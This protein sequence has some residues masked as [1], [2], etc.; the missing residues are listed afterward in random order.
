MQAVA[1]EN[2]LAE[3]AVPAGTRRRRGRAGPA[4][5]HPGGGGRPL[6]SRHRR[7]RARAGRDR[8][9]RRR[10]AGRASCPAPVRSVRRS[11][12]TA[13]SSSTSPRWSS[14]P[15]IHPPVSWRRS[16]SGRT[17]SGPWGAAASTCS[18]NW[19]TRR[20]WPRCSPTSAALRAVPTRGVIVTAG[21]GAC[22]RRLRVPLL[23]T[24]G[25]R[26]RRPGD[27]VRPLRPRPL[28]GRGARP[29]RAAGAPDLGSGRRAADPGRSGRSGRDRR[30]GGH[31]RPRPALR[32]TGPLAAA[33][34]P[35][36][37]PGTSIMTL[38]KL[39]LPARYSCAS[40]TRASG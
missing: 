17:W 24:G 11:G 29:H 10:R 35:A 25:R 36:Q 33:A 16:G 32:L 26:G 30:S 31:G 8:P 14:T 5:V 4:L 27:R 34:A 15:P 6:R 22:R 1:A 28:L 9:P 20:P 19:P 12:P 21:G 2:N 40:P 38:P 23:R 7:G 13:G 39:S 37:V 18:S 3:T